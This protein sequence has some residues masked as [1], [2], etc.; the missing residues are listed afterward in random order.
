VETE[1]FLLCTITLTGKPKPTKYGLRSE[2]IAELVKTNCKTFEYSSKIKIVCWKNT[3]EKAAK[4]Q[5]GQRFIVFFKK[6][7]LNDTDW[8]GNTIKSVSASAIWRVTQRE[9]DMYSI[10]SNGQYDPFSKLIV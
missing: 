4:F 7:N 5:K 10:N 1:P 3:A 9:F 2:V 6:F 8:K